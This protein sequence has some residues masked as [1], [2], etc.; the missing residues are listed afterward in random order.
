MYKYL[1][2]TVHRLVDL[3]HEYDAEVVEFFNT[4]EHLGG[5]STVNFVRGPMFHG[6]GKG[7]VKKPEEANTN[8]G[9]PSKPTRQKMKGGY[10]TASGVLK[11]MHLG[12]LKFVSG[13]TA[14]I[15][16]VIDTPNIR[17]F[18]AAMQN[19]GTALQPGIIFDEVQCWFESKG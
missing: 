16:P 8:L 9:G 13:E 19:D 17:V 7:G 10:T 18:G 12:F 4:I 2:D 5:E 1:Q 11:D 15:A 6:T 3:N 14:Q